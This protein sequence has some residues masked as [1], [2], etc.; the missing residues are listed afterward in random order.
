[1]ATKKKPINVSKWKLRKSFSCEDLVLVCLLEENSVK[2][3]RDIVKKQRSKYVFTNAECLS[4][5]LLGYEMFTDEGIEFQKFYIESII[6]ENNKILAIT[7]ENQY[8]ALNIENINESN[9]NVLEDTKNALNAFE[10]NL[11]ELDNK[12]TKL[13]EG[14]LEK[15]AEVSNLLENGELYLEVSTETPTIYYKFD[16]KKLLPIVAS[17]KAGMFK[18][19]IAIRSGKPGSDYVEF[20]FSLCGL[21]DPCQCSENIKSVLINNKMNG[22]IYWGREMETCLPYTLKRFQF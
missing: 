1:M 12:I 3:K 14:E 16:N 20:Q 21:L 4:Y 11:E 9:R 10:I 15:Q 8:I 22:T 18:D 7:T 5:G 13:I 2:K 17:Y 6:K 19:F